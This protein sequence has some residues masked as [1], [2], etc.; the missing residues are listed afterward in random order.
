[1]KN[2]VGIAF[3][4]LCVSAQP[5]AGRGAASNVKSNEDFGVDIDRFIGKA[6]ES[7]T[8]LSHGLLYT[9]SM[10]R[11]G[12]PNHPGLHGAVLEYHKDISTA[13]LLPK[14]RTPMVTLAD[15]F[16]FYVEN[17]EGRLE[18]D[19][20][21]WDLRENI[22]VLVP[23]NAPHRFLNDS[24]K[25]LNMIMITW[26]PTAQPRQDILVRDI[27]MLPWCEE[28]VHWNNTSKCVFGAA[29]GL[30]QSERMLMVMLQPRAMSQPHSHPPGMEETWTKVTP[31]S[32]WILIGSELRE[33]SENTA[34]LVPPTNETEHANLNLTNDRVD[35]YVYWAHGAPPAPGS[36]SPTS[37]ANAGRGGSGRSSNP[38]VVRDRA[39]TE[40]ANIA[41]KPLK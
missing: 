9:H 41:G 1:M 3:V 22:A 27:N 12:D 38:N 2:F 25:P 7:P 8:H 5:P 40:A 28:A 6:S 32:A 30:F 11:A 34:Y 29:D 14:N 17:G 23:P 37:T 15:Q 39:S 18:D 24:E 4:C 33:M 26:T 21:Y 20:Q 31:G 10:L 35:W 13:T 19:K 36:A 16:L